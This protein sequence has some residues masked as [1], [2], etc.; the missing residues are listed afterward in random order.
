M[1]NQRAKNKVYLGG[2]LERGF[3]Q[4]IVKL[5]KR[6]GMEHNKF[7]FV[8]Q[9]LEEALEQRMPDIID[10]DTGAIVS[11]ETTFTRMGEEILESVIK[12]RTPLFSSLST[13]S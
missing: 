9:L 1:P 12:T 11:G 10:I 2:F 8:T 5:A 3:H 4:Q 7:G 13:F 6:A